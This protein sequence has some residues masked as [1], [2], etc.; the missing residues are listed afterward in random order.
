MENKA[1][2]NKLQGPLSLDIIYEIMTDMTS[3]SDVCHLTDVNKLCTIYTTSYGCIVQCIQ[4]V[5]N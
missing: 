1:W 3:T 5:H 2:T 4:Q